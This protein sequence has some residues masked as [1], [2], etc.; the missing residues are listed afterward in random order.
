MC[1]LPERSSIRQMTLMVPSDPLPLPL[2]PASGGVMCFS[3]IT[4]DI[5][6]ACGT[7]RFWNT[8]GK[9]RAAPHLTVPLWRPADK[10]RLSQGEGEVRSGGTG[11]RWEE[12][13]GN[14]AGKRA[15]WVSEGSGSCVHQILAHFSDL[16]HLH[17]SI[18]SC[19][20]YTAGASLNRPTRQGCSTMQ[21][22]IDALPHGMLD[23]IGL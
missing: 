16:I 11:E 20:S 7:A 4:N 9:A 18:Q 3:V 8:G 19:T 13:G 14:R 10:G 17:G 5:L 23:R 12:R 21:N 1:L 6:K 22:A 2:E 15:D